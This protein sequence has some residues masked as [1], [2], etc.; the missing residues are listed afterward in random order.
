MLRPNLSPPVYPAD[1]ACV[2]QCSLQV[3][4]LRRQEE[5]QL[6]LKKPR[7]LR[8]GKVNLIPTKL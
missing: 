3:S 8:A 2:R 4:A 6:D 5:V 1:G 7:N